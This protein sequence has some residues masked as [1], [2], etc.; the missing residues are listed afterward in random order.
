MRPIHPIPPAK[1][2]PRRFTLA[3]AYVSSA[4]VSEPLLVHVQDA[5][6]AD[7]ARNQL[8]AALPLSVA[9]H[10]FPGH[11]HPVLGE[12]P[13]WVLVD[14][15]LYDRGGRPVAGAPFAADELQGE[16][17]EPARPSSTG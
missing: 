15:A 13:P 8:L 2:H 3:G 14:G 9:L 6:S 17:P 4:G 7:D 16:S 11:V 10:A 5:A 12:T 1:F